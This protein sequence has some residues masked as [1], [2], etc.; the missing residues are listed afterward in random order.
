M[1]AT[2]LSKTLF[3]F[4]QLR[5]AQELTTTFKKKLIAAWQWL[6][7]GVKKGCINNYKDCAPLLS[8]SQQPGARRKSSVE[9]EVSEGRGEKAEAKLPEGL[10]ER[11]GQ[12]LHR[13][14][15]VFQ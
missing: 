13:D 2:K 7:K 4:K 1:L 15:T 12:Q 3:P 8:F 11:E 10:G 14:R 6:K 5:I 9:H